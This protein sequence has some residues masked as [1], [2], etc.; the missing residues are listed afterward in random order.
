MAPA[1]GRLV[2]G[3]KTIEGN[4]YFLQYKTGEM[5]KGWKTLG[6][7]KYYFNEQTGIMKKGMLT[8]NGKKYYFDKETENSISVG[9]PSAE[10][11]ISLSV[12]PA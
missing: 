12:K 6:K 2:T 9:N 11:H 5:I 1:T 8:L 10:R 3:L 4:T 7:D